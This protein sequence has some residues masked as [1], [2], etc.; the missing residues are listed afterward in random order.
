M[1]NFGITFIGFHGIKYME[2]FERLI[3]SLK[4][5]TTFTKRSIIN[6]LQVPVYA[7]GFTI[8]QAIAT[9]T[10]TET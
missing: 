10:S 3:N 6:V 8:N 4:P 2:L 1:Y 7:S 9:L 5:L